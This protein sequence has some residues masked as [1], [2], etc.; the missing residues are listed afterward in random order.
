VEPAGRAGRLAVD[1]SRGGKVEESDERETRKHA[2]TEGIHVGLR[3][4]RERP[5]AGGTSALR[6]D[7]EWSVEDVLY[8]TGR[9]QS[10]V[11]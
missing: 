5:D 9:M 10:S 8:G 6:S 2:E 11:M 1:L 7:L 4:G 3:C